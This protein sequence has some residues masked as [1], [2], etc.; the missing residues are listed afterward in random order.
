MKVLVTGATGLIGHR[1]VTALHAAGRA[2]RVVTRDPQHVRHPKTVEVIDLER[3]HARARGAARSRR[4]RAPRGR[5]GVR[6][7]ADQGAPR[8]DPHQPRRLDRV[9]RAV[10][11]CAA[12]RRAARRA[13]S[14]HRRSATTATTAT[15][16]ST[17]PPRPATTSSPRS[18]S[19]G[20]APRARRAATA[21][22]PTSL[23]FG[24]V[25]AGEGGA[26][27]LMAAAVPR[28]L[29]RTARKR[30]PVVSVDPC[31]G[32]G[33]A[34]V[35]CARRLAL[36]G[37]RERGVARDRHERRAD[38][39]RS[40]ACCAAPPCF[41]CRRSRCG[42]RSASSRASCSAAAARF[43]APRRSAASASRT[44]SSSRRCARRSA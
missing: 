18:A 42:S 14:A 19:T 26:L 9:D 31:R 21:C 28:R 2:V 39:K 20:S 10:A 4:D 5:A 43:R 30:P 7:S 29:R 12:R 3:P 22:G 36:V 32:R 41:R 35:R 8:A 13:S 11:G 15:P 17:S 27:P 40:G 25:L 23:R 33:R 1:V 24:V 37:S 38:A 16:S 6:R 44:P 34:R